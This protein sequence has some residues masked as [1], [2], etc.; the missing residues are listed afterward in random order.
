MCCTCCRERATSDC[1]TRALRRFNARCTSA[2]VPGIRQLLGARG[3]RV[4]ARYLR[5][6]GYAIVRRN[7]RGRHG[8]VDLIALDGEVLVFVE[9]K[10]RAQDRYGDPLEAVD[11][12]KQRQI[13]GVAE[14]FIR[15]HDLHDRAVR[16]DVVG[17][18]RRG[19]RWEVELIRDAF[20]GTGRF[21]F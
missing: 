10:T 11:V 16:F 3:E 14:E 13:V 2:G 21:T 5:R 6:R 20:E 12:R 18:R 1:V 9:V 15:A 19:W 4:A 17:L 8:E 7:Y